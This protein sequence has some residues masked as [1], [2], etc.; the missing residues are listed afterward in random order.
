MMNTRTSSNCLLI[1]VVATFVFFAFPPPCFPWSWKQTPTRFGDTFNSQKFFKDG[2][3][4]ALAVYDD[5]TGIVR[6]H[7]ALGVGWGGKS[8]IFVP[9]GV[10]DIPPGIFDAA[11][12]SGGAYIVTVVISDATPPEERVHEIW[13]LRRA[14]G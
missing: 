13:N 11:M 2:E 9:S 3:N 10:Y 7:F 6:N 14:G 12:N 4:H 1:L 8:S 5:I